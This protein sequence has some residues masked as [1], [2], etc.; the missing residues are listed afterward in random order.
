MKNLTAAASRSHNSANTAAAEE[1]RTMRLRHES[2]NS[3]L[4]DLQN[5][6]AA[7]NVS[8]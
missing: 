2:L 7:L 5:E 1:L 4:N 3:T 8:T 6:N